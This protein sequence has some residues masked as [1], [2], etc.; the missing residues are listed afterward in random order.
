MGVPGDH[1]VDP[2]R[3]RIDLDGDRYVREIWVAEGGGI[4][5]LTAGPADTAPRWSLDGTKLAFL[6]ALVRSLRPGGQLVLVDLMRPERSPLSAQVAEAWRR[7]QR[8]GGVSGEALD[9][10]AQIQGF[11]PIGIARL[12]ALVE[13]A[14]LSDPAPFFQALD[15]QGFLLQRRE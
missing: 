1:H 11:H 9:P 3:T 15:F 10:T 8:A 7:F 2:R 14:G 12:T 6:T 5:R 13:A 4:R